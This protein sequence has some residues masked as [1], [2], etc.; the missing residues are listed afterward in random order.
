MR[1]VALLVAALAGSLWAGECA[2]V[3]GDRILAGDLARLRPLFGALDPTV[4]IGYAPAPGRRRTL[5]PEELARLARRYQLP[6]TSLEG[7]CFERAAEVLSPER[8]LE[9]M[10][11]ALG[12]PEARIEIVEFSRYPVPRGELSFARNGLASPPP[13]RPEAP[14]LWRGRVLY[15]GR[16]SVGI[17]AR[18][19]I[20]VP[21]QW[22]FARRDLEPGR[23]IEAA[24]LEERLVETFPA[25]R[26][27]VFRVADVAGATP[28]R[29]IRAGEAIEAGWLRRPPEVER[30]DAVTVEVASGAARLVVEARAET[31]GRRGEPVAVRNPATGRRFTAVV[32]GRGRASLRV[33]GKGSAP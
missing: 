7:V 16:R 28:R 31:A 24:D 1:R 14:V 8:L 5:E 11:A 33:G 19:R 9:A 6:E 2:A 18:V 4:V 13:G 23:P 12:E 17:W 21:G 25:R 3:E 20:R 10:R 26:N 30:G 15:D 27:A 22:V 32:E 29:R